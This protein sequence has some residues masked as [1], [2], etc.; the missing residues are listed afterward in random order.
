M[1]YSLKGRQGSYQADC[2]TSAAQDIPDWF[3][4]SLLEE[5]ET[6]IRLDIKFWLER[7]LNKSDSIFASFFFFF[8]SNISRTMVTFGMLRIAI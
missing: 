5:A 8:I 3:K 6:A 7:Q 1:T 2:L 4:I